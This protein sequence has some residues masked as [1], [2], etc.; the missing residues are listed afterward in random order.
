MGNKNK[1]QQDDRNQ[2]DSKHDEEVNPLI[3]ENAKLKEDL[4]AANEQ[5]KRMQADFENY[6]KRLSEEADRSRK[7]A[8][9]RIIIELLPLMDNL[10]RAINN[11]EEGADIS[12]LKKG[13]EL[14]YKQ[15]N[16]VLSREG[17]KCIKCEGESYDPNFAEVLMCEDNPDYDEDTV[18][19]DLE[20]GYILGDKVIRPAKVK[21]C[22]RQ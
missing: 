7:Y 14:I 8:S 1:N 13:I 12:S 10:E 2:Q 9:E 4:D 6:K 19:E 11:I 21:V 15:M 17:L 5:I 18:I 20:K 3:E 16:D 22:R